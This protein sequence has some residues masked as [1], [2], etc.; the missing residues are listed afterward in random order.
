MGNSYS[1]ACTLTEEEV[2][3]FVQQTTF[4]NNEVRALFVHF[5]RMSANNE[6]MTRKLVFVNLDDPLQKLNG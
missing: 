1:S 4:T 2:G 3:A 6:F 5:K